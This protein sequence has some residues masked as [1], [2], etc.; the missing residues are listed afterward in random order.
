M[1]FRTARHYSPSCYIVLVSYLLK[2]TSKTFLFSIWNRRVYFGLIKPQLVDKE[3]AGDGDS[4]LFTNV[5][6]SRY[7][8]SVLELGIYVYLLVLVG[9]KKQF[10]ITFNSS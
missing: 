4:V 9:K 7:K 3:G 10:L 6:L 1:I 5:S 2:R 8:I